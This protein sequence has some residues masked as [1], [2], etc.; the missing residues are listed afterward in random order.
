M[1]KNK[2]N[3]KREKQ[4]QL[5]K[6]INNLIQIKQ[7]IKEQQLKEQHIKEQQLNNNKLKNEN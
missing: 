4:Q 5:I 7:Q 3:I 2:L 1:F 6:N